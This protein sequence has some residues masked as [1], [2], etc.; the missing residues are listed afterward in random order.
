M[1][2]VKECAILICVVKPRFLRFTQF[3]LLLLGECGNKRLIGFIKAFVL[4][5]EFF[6][7]AVQGIKSHS[8]SFR[9]ATLELLRKQTFVT[10]MSEL[11]NQ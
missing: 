9:F 6:V 4:A 10:R 7:Y 8:I 2:I 1:A 3:I 5:R 11:T